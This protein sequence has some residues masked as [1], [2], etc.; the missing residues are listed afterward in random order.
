MDTGQHYQDGMLT[1]KY[2]CDYSYV[3]SRAFEEISGE[4]IRKTRRREASLF[5]EWQVGK[6]NTLDSYNMYCFPALAWKP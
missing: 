4:L 1:C 2:V 5:E 6:R 3:V